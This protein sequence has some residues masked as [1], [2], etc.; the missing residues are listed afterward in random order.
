MQFG[1][2]YQTAPELRVP[3]WIDGNGEPMDIPLRLDD[4]GDGYKIIFAFQ[5][6]C[7]GCHSGGFPTLQRLYRALKDRG[8]GFAAIQT[9]FQGAAVNTVDNKLRTNQ[10]QYGLPIP[11]GHDLPLD[12][13]RHSSFMEDY[14][15]AGTPW[16]T[17]IDRSGRVVFADFRLDAD[18]FL[19]AL[20]A[21][22]LRI[23]AA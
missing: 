15:S 4:L 6:W 5:H 2:V 19:A 18:R 13:N 3:I 10:E 17:V 21:G 14:R 1:R 20:D 11:F 9:V 16:F 22:H 8:F 23:N 12:G 7:P